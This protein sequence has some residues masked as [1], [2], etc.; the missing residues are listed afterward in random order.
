VYK[1]FVKEFQTA[2]EFEDFLNGAAEN[3]Y[4]P[5]DGEYIIT[6]HGLRRVVLVEDLGPEDVYYVV[7]VQY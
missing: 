4:D 2:K 5:R 1:K 6:H 7:G 3:P